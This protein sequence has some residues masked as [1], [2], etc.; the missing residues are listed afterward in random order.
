MPAP[1][2]IVYL[3]AAAWIQLILPEKNRFVALSF[4]LVCKAILSKQHVR[5]R[6]AIFSVTNLQAHM[7]NPLS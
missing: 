1:S 3:K 7:A 6:T 4:R 2:F 5:W